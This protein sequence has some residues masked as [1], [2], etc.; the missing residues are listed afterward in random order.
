MG[1]RGDL[2]LDPPSAGRRLEI[3]T[4]AR[5]VLKKRF[6]LISWSMTMKTQS[7][8]GKTVKTTAGKTRGTARR[9]EPA[10]AAPR[11]PRIK[12]PVGRYVDEHWGALGKDYKLEY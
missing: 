8:K 5:E 12:D 3:A 1:T 11:R 10:V 6:P 7:A 9:A 2:R 4:L